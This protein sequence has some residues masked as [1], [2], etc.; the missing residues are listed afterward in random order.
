[1]TFEEFYNRD[2][3]ER[4]ASPVCRLFHLLGPVASAAYLGAVAER[5]AWR[6]L[7]LLPVPTYL[8]AWVGHLAAGNRP[9]FFEHP[10]WSVRAYWKMIGEMV[11]DNLFPGQRVSR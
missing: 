6:W 4:H 8:M 5:G 1:M 10:I 9:T 2:Y 7:P 3:R 11:A